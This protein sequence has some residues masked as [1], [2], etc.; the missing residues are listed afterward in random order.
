MRNRAW[1][2]GLHALRRHVRR[3]RGG[4]HADETALVHRLLRDGPRN[5]VMVDVGAHHGHALEPFAL[6]RWAVHAFE[7][8]R[9]NRRELERR[10]G[11]WP[12][13]RIDDRALSDREAASAAFYRSS[14]SDGISSLHPFHP[15]HTEG[16]AVAVTT[17]AAYLLETG[18]D[19]V[20]FL[21][22]DAEGHDL[23]VLRGVP[24]ERLRPGVVVCEFDE[25]KGRTVDGGYHALGGFLADRGYLILVSE[26][27]PIVEYG[28]RHRWRRFVQYPAALLD[29]AAWG[30]LIAVRDAVTFDRLLR[31]A[32]VPRRAGARD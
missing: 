6:D 10:W 15:S 17:L 3:L 14:V 18:L 16:P 1:R 26:W 24:W 31:L 19:R 11:G 12:G 7:P 27:E 21:K 13:V 23:H 30:N 29:G 25:A 22:V 32:R 9:L 5:R 4:R 2:R 8:D 20:D 28:L